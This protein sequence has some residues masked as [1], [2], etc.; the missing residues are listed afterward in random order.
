MIVRDQ[1]SKETI[2]SLK[3]KPLLFRSPFYRKI[4]PVRPGYL[5]Q[6]TWDQIFGIWTMAFM[7]NFNENVR[8]PYLYTKKIQ[9][10]F[11][12]ISDSGAG[13]VNQEPHLY[14][15]TFELFFI[16]ITVLLV[17][18]KGT[19]TLTLTLHEEPN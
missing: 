6:V 18:K 17:Y 11:L 19:L 13:I 3:V 2:L 9:K 15:R 5:S 14:Y 16:Y 8:L 10:F 12:K 7:P 4:L 1:Y